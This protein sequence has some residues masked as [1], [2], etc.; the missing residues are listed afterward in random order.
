MT[1]AIITAALIISVPIWA[2]FYLIK[3]VVDEE[4]EA[5]LDK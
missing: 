3:S 1:A 2:I 5:D 4:Y